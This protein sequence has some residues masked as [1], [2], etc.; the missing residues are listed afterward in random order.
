MD[1]LNNIDHKNIFLIMNTIGIESN[2]IKTIE[3]K[4]YNFLLSINDLLQ[5]N[6]FYINNI[7]KYIEFIIKQQLLP[8]ISTTL[9]YLKSS[10]LIS[11]EHLN[12]KISTKKKI[13]IF[14]LLNSFESLLIKY[15]NK[16]YSMCYR[17]FF[18]TKNEQKIKYYGKKLKNI[19]KELQN[20]QN[21]FFTLY[22]FKYYLD[23]SNNPL[24]NKTIN[25]IFCGY[26]IKCGLNIF[27]EIKNIF[28]IYKLKDENNNNN[29]IKIKENNELDTKKLNENNICILCLN[30]FK[31]VCCTPC[32]HLFCWSCI[33]IFLNEQNFC[34]KCKQ[35]C[36][37]QEILFLQNY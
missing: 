20:F 15:I 34:P 36:K 6:T 10:Q 33:H 24:I 18:K 13:Y 30:E 23:S 9:Y 1:Y 27:R 32:G 4:I 19:F 26:S 22:Q 14:L 35:K 37:P 8:I 12:I 7:L 2:I 17:F 5:N 28:Y 11:E 29:C 31:D 3:I 16:I 25:F 21:I